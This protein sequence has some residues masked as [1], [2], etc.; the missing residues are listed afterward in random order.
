MAKSLAA[1][2]CGAVLKFVV[3]LISNVLLLALMVWLVSVNRWWSWI[4]FF[5]VGPG[6]VFYSVRQLPSWV[7]DTIKLL[8]ARNEDEF[9]EVNEELFENRLKRAMKAGSGRRGGI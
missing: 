9:R 2:K 4:L 7:S 8:K 6:A 5:I 3:N 1:L